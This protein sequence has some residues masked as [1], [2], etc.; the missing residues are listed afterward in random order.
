MKQEMIFSTSSR[1]SLAIGDERRVDA[2][3][4]PPRGGSIV[5][6]WAHNHLIPAMVR[7]QSLSTNN[8]IATAQREG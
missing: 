5:M 7:Y 3:W 8:S 1:G 6:S 2:S 4:V